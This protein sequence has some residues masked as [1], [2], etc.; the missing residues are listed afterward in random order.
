M[1]DALLCIL[2]GAHADATAESVHA[3]DAAYLGS[4]AQCDVPVMKARTGAG[5]RGVDDESL[6]EGFQINH[7][8]D[9]VIGQRQQGLA[10]AALPDM[11][12]SPC[13]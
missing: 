10:Q 5:A 6:P 11:H 7:H 1:T 12:T 2:A 4:C 3:T 9:K 13:A 8:I